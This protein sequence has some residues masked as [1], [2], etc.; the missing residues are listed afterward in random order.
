M[1]WSDMFFH[2][3]SAS[4]QGSY[5]RDCV[6]T[7]EILDGVPV[8][9]DLIYWD[10]YTEDPAYHRQIMAQHRLFQSKTYF[11]GGIFTWLS[12][13]CDIKKTLRASLVTLEA[14]KEQKIRGVIA[15]MWGDNGAEGNALITGLYALNAYAE[16][17]WQGAYDTAWADSR[18]QAVT[19]CKADAM[20]TLDD[21]NHLPGL[22]P[23][24]YSKSR[25]PVA[26]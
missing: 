13:L 20:K 9:M 17:C 16:F 2:L 4:K 24:R 5:P 7:R 11:A 12:P 3:A 26:V 10:Y 8:D 15:T 14:C 6:F 1:M 23:G 18:F 21:F 19:G 22:T 25:P